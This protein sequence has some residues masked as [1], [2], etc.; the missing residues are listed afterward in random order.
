MNQTPNVDPG[1]IQKFEALASRW[2]DPN[3]EFKPLHEINPLRLGYIQ[4]QSQLTG[5]K[6]LDVGCGGG[7]LAESMAAVNAEVTGIDMGLAPLEVARLH[8]LESGLEVDYQQIPV[9]ELASKQPASFDVVTCMEMLEHVPDPSSVVRA[10]FDLVKPGGHVFFSTINRNPKAYLFAI[11][12]A[13]YLL[14]LLPKG[15]HD[16]AKFIRPSE[17]NKWIRETGLETLDISGMTYN[18]FSQAYKLDPNDVDVNYL[19]ATTKP[20]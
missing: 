3:S 7:I 4:E 17:L 2:W 6:V 16:Y 14:Q 1:E 10:C 9:E 18:P 19:I 12:G 8:L 15:T 20:E 5:K 11:V 13:E